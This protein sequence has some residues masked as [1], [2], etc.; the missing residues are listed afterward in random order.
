MRRLNPA[1]VAAQPGDNWQ[2]VVLTVVSADQRAFVL[3]YAAAT[4]T[5]GDAKVRVEYNGGT[6][7]APNDFTTSGTAMTWA[8]T[9]PLSVGES[10]TLWIVPQST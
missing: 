4:D 3:P 1:P 10:L 8:G 7:N 9:I 2:Q 6:Y 5:D